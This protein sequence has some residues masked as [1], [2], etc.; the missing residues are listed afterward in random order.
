MRHLLSFVTSFTK[1]KRVLNHTVFTNLRNA[2]IFTYTGAQ[3]GL[4]HP[5]TKRR[6][7]FNSHFHCIDA[8]FFKQAAYFHFMN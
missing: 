5:L 8:L 1:R 2:A 7:Q 3:V 6:I 4:A